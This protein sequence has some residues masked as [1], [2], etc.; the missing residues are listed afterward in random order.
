MILFRRIENEADTLFEQTYSLYES[1]FPIIER[2]SAA[3]LRQVL[4]S[5]KKFKISAILKD[6]QF[7]GLF[8]DWQFEDFVYAEHFAIL[9]ALRGKHIG[10]EVVTKYLENTG[11][12]IV[13]EVEKPDN[14][15]A[16][17]RIE[18]YKRLG[19]RLLPFE[20]AQPYYDGSGRLFPMLL[21][22]NDSDFAHQNIFRITDTIYKNVYHYGKE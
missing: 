16:K 13:F 6:N 11:S 10:S 12:P 22:T 9:P 5:E 8:S 3:A 7:V 18:F 19:F 20:Y 1:A 14:E 15:M 4:N 2:R 17:R 21:M